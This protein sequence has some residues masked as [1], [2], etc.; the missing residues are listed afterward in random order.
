MPESNRPPVRIE[1]QKPSEA[2]PPA[3]KEVPQQN[4]GIAARLR[5]MSDHPRAALQWLSNIK[6]ES[7][8]KVGMKAGRATQDAMSTQGEPPPLKD[9]RQPNS[10]G[11]EITDPLLQKENAYFEEFGNKLKPE[12]RE[13]GVQDLRDRYKHEGTSAS[14]VLA[15]IEAFAERAGLSHTEVPELRGQ[16]FNSEKTGEKVGQIVQEHIDRL[17]N[18]DQGIRNP[19]KHKLVTEETQ[20]YLDLVSQAHAEGDLPSDLSAQNVLELVTDNVW[21]LAYQDRAARENWLGDHGVR[22]LVGHNIAVGEQL[23]DELVRNGQQVKGIDRLLMHQVMID[24]DMGYAMDPVRGPV[25]KGQFGADAGHN[26]LA[27]KLVREQGEQGGAMA[28]VFSQKQL[29]VVHE[30]ILHHDSSQIDFKIGDPSQEARNENM[31]SVIHAADNTHAFEDKLPE[32]LYGYPDTLQYLHL[33]RTA[34]EIR[35]PVLVGQIRDQL[36]D[37]IRSHREFTDDDKEALLTAVAT[38]NEK[39]YA[40]TVPR[41]AGNK[42]EFRINEQGQLS[43]SVTESAIHRDAVRLFNQQA[44]EQLAKFASDITGRKDIDIYQTDVVLSSNERVQIRVYKPGQN[45]EKSDYQQRVESVIVKDQAF[46]DYSFGAG[47]QL[48]DEQL[49]IMQMLA[50]KA[51][52]SLPDDSLEKTNMVNKVDS[53]KAQRKELLV[54]YLNNKKIG[55]FTQE[56]SQ[57]LAA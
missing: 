56:Q 53:I 51:A 29:A 2:A 43:I 35:D 50:H 49:S 46:R 17:F 12:S 37:S 3:K 21:K 18:S 42:P 54:S 22:H 55:T 41:I 57:P 14:F 30:G 32:V 39:S 26:L 10:E 20:R 24:H 28:S 47:D 44:G 31:Y 38:V 36:A 34:G 27:A 7:L 40:R 5:S 4:K 23:F 1:A 19:E 15:Q 52:H 8:M 45:E 48:G 9:S 25:A 16:V 6:A 11:K 13:K 33:M